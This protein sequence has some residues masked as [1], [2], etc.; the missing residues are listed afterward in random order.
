MT[1]NC[2]SILLDTAVRRV[3]GSAATPLHTLDAGAL[4]EILT[5]WQRLRRNRRLD[6]IDRA[7]PLAV[8][9]QS[10]A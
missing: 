2:D 3:T 1:L 7:D 8:L 5:E 10:A 4:V 9:N 6:P